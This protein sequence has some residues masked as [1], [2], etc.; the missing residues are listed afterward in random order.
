M[1]SVVDEF[2]L[3][4][5]SPP[6]TPAAPDWMAPSAANKASVSASIIHNDSNDLAQ[7]EQACIAM[8]E[9]LQEIAT[10]YGIS[11]ND[12]AHHHFHHDPRVIWAVQESPQGPGT[13][14]YE[15]GGAPPYGVQ[16]W[17]ELVDRW[18]AGGM[19][20]STTGVNMTSNSTPSPRERVV[21][22]Q[23]PPVLDLSLIHI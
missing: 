14:V 12:A 20:C 22:N 21:D 19:D 7:M 4:A 11:L 13:Q 8:K 9:G 15:G 17:L 1:T 23:L 3:E 2:G 5:L 18:I 10:N 6:G 16:E